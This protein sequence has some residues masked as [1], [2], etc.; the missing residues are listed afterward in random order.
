MV[1]ING[2]QLSSHFAE[3]VLY[4]E[5]KLLSCVSIIQRKGCAVTRVTVSAAWGDSDQSTSRYDLTSLKR[6]PAKRG[7]R[8]VRYSSSICHSVTVTV[9]GSLGLRTVR[10]VDGCLRRA[11][12]ESSKCS[13]TA[14]LILQ[15]SRVPGPE[16]HKS[17]S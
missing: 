14:V 5:Y 16:S 13:L 11:D 4:R 2:V 15:A 6:V 1:P 12:Q 7:R 9:V 10:D 8:D 3:N 17:R